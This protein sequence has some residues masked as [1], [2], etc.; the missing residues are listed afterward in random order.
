MGKIWVHLSMVLF[1]LFFVGRSTAFEEKIT[2]ATAQA[3]YE[4]GNQLFIQAKYKN[5]TESFN[6]AL[7][8]DPTHLL[9]W[10][11][12]GYSLHFLE[13]DTEALSAFDSAIKLNNEFIFAIAGKVSALKGMGR[14]TEAETFL[15]DNT[16]IKPKENDALSYY[17][18]GITNAL[19]A[20]YDLAIIDFT[21]AIKINPKFALVYNDRGLAYGNQDKYD[22]AITDFTEAIKINTQYAFAYLNRGSCY[23][24]KGEYDLGIEDLNSA[25]KINPQFALAYVCRGCAYINKKDYNSAKLDF[26]KAVE[27]DQTGQDGQSARKGL[28]QLRKMGY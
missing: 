12:K 24:L 15:L 5:A 9:A 16:H 1:V 8:I 4:Q 25:L 7:I 6:K 22:L 13:R 3:L 27:L 21:E 10:C 19:K 26:E 17:G 14:E 20:K 28:E 11:Y 23:T 2:T 18:H